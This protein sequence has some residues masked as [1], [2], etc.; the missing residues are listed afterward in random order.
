M[1]SD[2]FAA[3]FPR[4]GARDLR[5]H[6]LILFGAMNTTVEWYDPAGPTALDELAA[7]ITDQFLTGVAP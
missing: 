4:R 3:I 1:W 2:L 6:R 5:L 7:A